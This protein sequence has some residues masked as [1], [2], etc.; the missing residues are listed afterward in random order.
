MD[1]KIT[2][3]RPAG[4]TTAYASPEQ[5]RSLQAQFEG[6]EDHEDI[7]INGYA[8]DN[9]SL[10]VVLYEMLTGKLPF[11]VK[12]EHYEEGLTPT[13]CLSSSWRCGTSLMQCCVFKMSG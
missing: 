5:L 12:E 10:R 2:D 13:R 7:L 3:V 8:S 6:D 9:F 1:L 11:V 4:A